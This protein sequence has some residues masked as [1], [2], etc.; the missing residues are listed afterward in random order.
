MIIGGGS[1]SSDCVAKVRQYLSS[2]RNES[3][4]SVAMLNFEKKKK[5][6]YSE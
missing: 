1:S 3:I 2:S 4:S 5:E 6:R